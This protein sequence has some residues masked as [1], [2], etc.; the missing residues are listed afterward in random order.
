VCPL[1]VV[2]I[3]TVPGPG[4]VPESAADIHIVVPGSPVTVGVAVGV[5]VVVDATGS[6][7]YMGI[8]FLRKICSGYLI[9]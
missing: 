4:L 2:G 8:S 9:D 7:V 1:R 3:Q 5:G 6:G